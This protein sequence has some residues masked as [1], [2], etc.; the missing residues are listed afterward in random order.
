MVTRNRQR[1]LETLH[2]A[3]VATNQLYADATVAYANSMGVPVL[4]MFN[5]GGVNAITGPALLN[6]V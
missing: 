5:K 6:G 4:N 2:R 3:I 1:S